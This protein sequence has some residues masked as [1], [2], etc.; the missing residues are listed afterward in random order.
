MAGMFYSLKEAA[1]RLGVTEDQ[2]KQLAKENKL[3]EFRDGSNLLFK[4]EEVN[5][6]LAEGI[7][8]G[9]DNLD[10]QELTAEEP[11]GEAVGD[12]AATSLSERWSQRAPAF[13]WSR[14]FH[15]LHACC[16]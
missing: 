11:A 7:G 14:P 5:A 6:L 1:Q 10:L 13:R 3:R 15:A 12:T 4:I 8:V 2:V 9:T 16:A